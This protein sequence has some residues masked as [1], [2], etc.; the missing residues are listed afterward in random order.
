[1]PSNDDSSLMFQ[2]PLDS[3]LFPISTYLISVLKKM[4]VDLSEV[5]SWWFSFEMR[6][7]RLRQN[8][9]VR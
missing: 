1:M 3:I 9:K 2:V 6:K 5:G 7:L 8:I 4:K